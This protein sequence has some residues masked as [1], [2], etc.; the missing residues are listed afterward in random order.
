MVYST[1]MLVRAICALCGAKEDLIADC[2]RRFESIGHRVDDHRKALIVLLQ[3]LERLSA[4]VEGC[5]NDT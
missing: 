4:P 2:D 5:K 1:K 3:E